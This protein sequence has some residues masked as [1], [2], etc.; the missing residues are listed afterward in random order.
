V[1][2]RTSSTETL[3]PRAVARWRLNGQHLDPPAS[4]NALE[5]V[6]TDLV[7]IQA[8]VASSAALSMAIRVRNGRIDDTPKAVAERRL[9]R[10]W[11]MRGTLHLWAADDYPLVVAALSRRETWRRPVWFRYFGVTEAEMERLIETIG[12]ILGDGRPRTRAELAEEIG[13]RL[14]PKQRKNLGGSWGTYLKPAAMRGLLCQAA[15][16]GNSVVFTRPDV[17]IGRWRT[18]NPDEALATLLRRYLRAYGPSTL[19]EIGRWWGDRIG[20]FKPTLESLG[21]DIVDVEFGGVRG[22]FLREELQ[23]VRSTGADGTPIL[24]GPFDPLTVG[25]GRRAWFIPSAH[26]TRVSRTAGWI[27]PVL[28]MHGVVAGVWASE[29]SGSRIHITIDPFDE[30]SARSRRA[31]ERAAGRVAESHDAE[32]DLTFGAVF[33]AP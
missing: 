25:L 3:D 26:L 27:S 1:A 30:P 15:G 13:G 32:L 2:R 33:P 18:V 31:I 9:I 24:L 12:D 6:A 4:R 22:L 28:L 16:E 10:S 14:G 23:S 19:T 5:T 11:G 20:S 7:G 8:Q 17:W 21:D 29:R